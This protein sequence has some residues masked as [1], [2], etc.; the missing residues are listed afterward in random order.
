MQVSF[1]SPVGV[2]RIEQAGDASQNVRRRCQKQRLDVAVSE[3]LDDGWEEVGHRSG[4][5]EA[6]KKSHQ[7]VSLDVAECELETLPEALLLLVYPVILAD[8]FL[9]P[10]SSKLTLLVCQPRSRPR[11]IGKN[12]EGKESDE[13]GDGS[14]N[15][16]Q[17][18]PAFRQSYFFSWSPNIYLPCSQSASAVH[19]PCNA[20]CYKAPKGPRD[21]GA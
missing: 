19:V 8:V 6:E 1:S 10:P 18:L 14:F 15:D 12:K 21:D 3:G 7:D 17:P 20:C 5:D 11:K 4:G 2:P 13:D 9:K 16:E